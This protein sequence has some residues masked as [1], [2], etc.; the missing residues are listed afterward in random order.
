MYYASYGRGRP[1]LLI[2]NG[3]G[4]ADDWGGVVPRLA[5]QYRVIIADTRGFGRSTRNATPYSYDLIASDYLALLDYLKV[6]K[7]V[8]VG[9]SDGGIVGFD[10]AIHHPKRIAGLFVQGANATNDGING[11]PADV[12][13]IK[14][15]LVRARAEYLRLSPT[16]GDY[17]A[18][19]KALDAMDEREPAFS[20]MQ[21]SSIRVPTVV[22]VADHEESIKPSHSRHLASVIP[23]ARTVTLQDVSH[24]AP[25]QDPTGF[26]DAVLAFLHSPQ[27][28]W[29]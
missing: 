29:R 16:P 1:V 13:A 28:N 9:T 23:H 25:L 27:I 10:I 21:L 6:G 8:V 24:F 17:S 20:D 12:T 2:H 4:D 14:L 26:S 15:A 5:G 18:F 19:R 22:A 7:V 3:L 11:H